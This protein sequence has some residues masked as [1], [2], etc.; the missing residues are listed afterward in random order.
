M[1][2]EAMPTFGTYNTRMQLCLLQRMY[3]FQHVK[4]VDAWFIWPYISRSETNVTS[5]YQ[6]PALYPLQSE[7]CLDEK[8]LSI[9]GW[10]ACPD[11]K[12]G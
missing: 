4:F 5:V 8:V 3:R 9:S 1:D 10:E 7:A 2:R 11:V 6:V 12:P